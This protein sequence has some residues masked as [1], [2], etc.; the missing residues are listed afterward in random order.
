MQA[1]VRKRV[2]VVPAQGRKR[3]EQEIEHLRERERAHDVIDPVRSQRDVARQRGKQGGG[4]G[5]GEHL[6]KQIVDTRHRR[7]HHRVGPDPKVGRV[8]EGNERGLTDDEV[9][10]ERGEREDER[11]RAEREQIGLRAIMRADREQR[12][13][14]KEQNRGGLAAHRHCLTGKRPEGRLKRTAAI[15]M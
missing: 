8:A 9:E 4:C 15:R 3:H 5:S 2:T 11:A 1:A 7:Q 13:P 10:R 14:R 12:Q 6:H